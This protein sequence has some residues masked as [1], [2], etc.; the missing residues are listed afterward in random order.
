MASKQQQSPLVRLRGIDVSTQV[1][2]ASATA[3]ELRPLLGRILEEGLA[4]LNSMPSGCQGEEEEGGEEGSKWKSKGIKTFAHSVSPVQL[5]ERT[6]TDEGKGGRSG[7]TWAMR[8]SVHQ[9]KAASGTA[10]WTEWERFIKREHAESEKAFTPTVLSTHLRRSWDCA[11][12][13]QDMTMGEDD[14]PWTDWTLKLQESVHKLPPPLQRRVFPVLQM[15]ASARHRRDFIVVQIAVRNHDDDDDK[16]NKDKAGAAAG[17][18]VVS[19]AYTSV[20]RVRDAV[21]PDQGVEWLMATTSDA[22]GL[23]PAW[24]QRL[25]VPGQIAKDVDLFLAWLVEERE[26]T[27]RRSS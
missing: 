3:Q 14:S 9:D 12:D 25:A 7:E 27:R 18:G 17:A 2:P 6:M 16:D 23:V 20:E 4:L 13:V 24:L 10:S 11:A 15:T 8:R 22:R 1:P 21:S 5:F 19:G 26:K